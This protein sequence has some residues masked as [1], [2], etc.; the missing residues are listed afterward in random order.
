MYIFPRK[1]TYSWLIA[2][3]DIVFC[4]FKE[5]KKFQKREKHEEIIDINS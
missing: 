2:E 3:I 5:K 1:S 4:F